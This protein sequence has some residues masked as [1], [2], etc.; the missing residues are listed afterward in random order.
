MIKKILVPIDGSKTAQKALEYAVDL[1]KQTG[2]PIVLL[3][4][5]D[6]SPFYGEPI[7][8]SKSTPT[9]LQENL[10]DY[11]MQTAEA[12][13]SKAEKICKSKGVESR[14]IVKAGHPVEEIIKT[15]GA[16]KVDLIVLGS[17]GKSALKAALLGSVAIG[18]MH[19]EKKIPVLV[20]RR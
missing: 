8:P 7:I 3:S 15:A 2:A 6:K 14:K 16:L 1:A 13:V 11:L 9:H 18:V 12:Y 20:V 4:V 10:E 19:T 17:H 5:I